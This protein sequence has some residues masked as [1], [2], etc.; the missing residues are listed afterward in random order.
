M[1]ELSHSGLHGETLGKS[2]T[3]SCL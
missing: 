3:R 2:F 1:N